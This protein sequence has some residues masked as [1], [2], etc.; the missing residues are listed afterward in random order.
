MRIPARKPK[1]LTLQMKVASL[2]RNKCEEIAFGQHP[3]GAYWTG[4][5]AF[6]G[7]RIHVYWQ[8]YSLRPAVD[9]VRI[10]YTMINGKRVYK[11]VYQKELLRIKSVL[12]ARLD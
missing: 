9:F 8:N 3:R 5:Y 10:T 1:I 6:E 2:I 11:Y 12:D 7:N 4:E